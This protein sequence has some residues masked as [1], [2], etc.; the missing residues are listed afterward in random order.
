VVNI[1][2]RT[3]THIIEIAMSAKYQTPIV[4]VETGTFNP[5]INSL[6]NI[7][8]V[9]NIISFFPGWLKR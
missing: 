7:P 4:T 1:L 5:G 6:N 3:T 9:V 8:A 2:I